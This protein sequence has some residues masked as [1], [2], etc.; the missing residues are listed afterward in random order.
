MTRQLREREPRARPVGVGRGAAGVRT[1]GQVAGQ[2]VRTDPER[3][4]AVLIMLSQLPTR[5]TGS[6]PGP[7]GH[8]S[9]SGIARSKVQGRR[10]GPQRGSEGKRRMSQAGPE[11]RRIEATG[12]PWSSV[13]PSEQRAAGGRGQPVPK[14]QTPH[15]CLRRR[16]QKLAVARTHRRTDL[17]GGEAVP[18]ERTP[19][20]F[21]W[22]PGSLPP[23]H[24]ARIPGL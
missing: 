12:E 1:A 9:L 13:A 18:S 3:V 23:G 5:V 17:A 6:E 19:C 7:A 14:P 22:S 20:H 16:T 4:E 21:P 11:K 10:K 2:T 24:F 8:G 15:P